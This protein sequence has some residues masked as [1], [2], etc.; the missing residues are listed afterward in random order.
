[1]DLEEGLL[2]KREE[3]EEK[4][5]VPLWLFT[6]FGLCWMVHLVS[7][8]QALLYRSY[9]LERF[10]LDQTSTYTSTM[11]LAQTMADLTE[12]PSYVTVGIVIGQ[13]DFVRNLR[14]EWKIFMRWV[15]ALIVCVQ[16]VL[17][18]LAFLPS[19]PVGDMETA[20][21]KRNAF[22]VWAFIHQGWYSLGA[23]L[24]LNVCTSFK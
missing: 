2:R 14:S 24:L 5:D 8:F 3:E 20:I 17:L 9:R 19:N 23:M 4:E 18:V 11:N 6:L 15:L 21:A 13:G 16:L 7:Y 1:M 10:P 22:V 12:L